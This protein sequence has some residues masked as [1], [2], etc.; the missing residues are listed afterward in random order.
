MTNPSV[1]W[2]TTKV[3]NMAYMFSLASTFHQPISGW[4]TPAVIYRVSMFERASSF[5]HP[6]GDWN[7]LAVTGMRYMFYEASS[8]HQNFATLSMLRSQAKNF[9]VKLILIEMIFYNESVA[10]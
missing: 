10:A 8:F 6:I 7:T 2:D 4:N 5:N 3:P 1:I 9:C